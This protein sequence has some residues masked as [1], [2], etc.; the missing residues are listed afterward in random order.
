VSHIL[1]EGIRV[2]DG[3]WRE[4]TQKQPGSELS[5]WHNASHRTD[6][7]CLKHTED[8][9]VTVCT[10]LTTVKFSKDNRIG[11]FHIFLRGQD[12]PYVALPTVRSSKIFQIFR[13]SRCLYHLTLPELRSGWF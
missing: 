6:Y 10:G 5:P 2:R 12:F 3:V 9:Q 13:V 1:E 7:N 11:G 4:M 8:S